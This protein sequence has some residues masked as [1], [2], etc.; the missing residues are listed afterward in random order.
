MKSQKKVKRVFLLVRLVLSTIIVLGAA[1]PV[2]ATTFEGTTVLTFAPPNPITLSGVGVTDVTFTTE[3]TS[4]A[5]A[6]VISA[7]KIQIQMAVDEYGNPVPAADAYDWESLNG[8]GSS[9]DASGFTTLEV[10]LDALGFECGTVAGF[11]AHY[12]GNPDRPGGDKVSNH[13]SEPPV[14]LTVACECPCDLTETAFAYDAV[15][16]TCFLDID[17]LNADRWG[18]T[19][20]PLA[21]GD[22][23]FDIYAG[24]GQCDIENGALVGEL[25]VSYSSGTATITYVMDSCRILTETH[26]YIGS[27]PLPTKDDKPTVAPGQYGNTH[28]GDDAPNAESDQYVIDGL[29]GD[30]YLIAHAVVCMEPELVPLDAQ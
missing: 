24:A 27:D 26:L 5:S 13:F 3:T 20:G 30:V 19:I 6:S 1:G 18:W 7:G 23:I 28:D 9:P 25:L 4:G 2:L 10:D 12:I 11:R 16:G 15:L 21:E 22:Y 17:G 14:D 29:S 8:A